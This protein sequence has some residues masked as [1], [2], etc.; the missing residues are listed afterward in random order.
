MD[1]LFSQ[2]LTKRQPHVAKL[3]TAS[4][5][6]GKLAHAYLL[7]GRAHE[8]KWLI[9]RHL[10]QFLNCR[11][12]DK[13][14]AGS[15]LQEVI[16]L[17]QVDALLWQAACQNCRWLFKDEHP[18][19]WYLLGAQAGKSGKIP[20]EAARN[21]SEEI[22]RSSEYTRIIVVEEANE[23][24]LHRPCANALLKTIEEPKSP[25]LFLLF[26]QGQDSVLQTIVSRCQV[27]PLVNDVQANLG[28]LRDIASG[29]KKFTSLVRERF[30]E[31]T[32]SFLA[33]LDKD[34]FFSSSYKLEDG[35]LRCR[36]HLSAKDALEL[37]RKLNDLLEE[38]V[39]PDTLFDACLE[40]DLRQVEA[41]LGVVKSADFASY[42]SDLLKLQEG[43]KR[44]LSQYVGKKA[45]CESFVLSWH[46]LRQNL[47]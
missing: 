30:P 31:E 25:C 12:E 37:A 26:S 10:A 18:K 42:L 40:F 45:V 21:L 1:S 46:E 47:K 3:F 20:V 34:A 4:L 27:V 19:A 22:S 23:Y 41:A 28:P 44:S 6:R 32:L 11:R 2:S 29:A 5:K 13:N 39:E 17:S 33:D 36:D 14:A 38:E 16:G 9:A 24:A 15:C 43:A 8:D 35:R 7:V